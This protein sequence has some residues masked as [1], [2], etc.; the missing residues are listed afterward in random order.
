MTGRGESTGRDEVRQGSEGGFGTAPPSASQ[1]QQAQS[2]AGDRG[3]GASSGGWR[4]AFVRAGKKAKDDN[5]TDAA[6]ALAYYGFLAIPSALLIAAGLFGLVA[7]PGAIQTIIDKLSSV[8]PKEAITLVEQSLTR[9]T[10]SNGTSFV[11][12][13]VGGLLALWTLSGAM[14]AL[15]RALNV[16][17]D[18]KET[19]KFVRQR[20]TALGMLAWILI[21]FVL[22][23]GMLVLGPHLAQWIGD[24][25]HERTVVEWIWWAAQWPILIGGL[26]LAFAGVLRLGPNV[27][28]PRWRLFSPGALLAVVVWLVAS[29]LFSLY[30][31]KFGSYNKAWG[32][33]AAVVI[34]LTWLWLSGVALLLGAELNAEVDRSG[35]HRG[36]PAGYE[37]QPAAKGAA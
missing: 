20:L 25:V 23:F 11:L 27:D 29:G 7:G 31:S 37:L 14:N 24:A 4:G 8:V 21:A 12:I 10:H 19:R 18:V 26:L 1:P 9:L 15:M 6:A 36:E 5:I 3:G 34:M 16:A 22:A 30:V 33:L 35:L 28:H 2:P 17:Y 32:S 13:I